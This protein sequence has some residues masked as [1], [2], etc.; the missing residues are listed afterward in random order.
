MKDT[1]SVNA[2]AHLRLARALPRFA[3]RLGVKDDFLSRLLDAADENPDAEVKVNAMIA[4]E[5][6]KTKK[7][8][9]LPLARPL[10][11]LAVQTPA[12]SKEPQ[13]GG[14]TLAEWITAL[15]SERT[16]I[17]AEIALPHCGPEGVRA[18]L[19]RDHDGVLPGLDLSQLSEVE[20][21]AIAPVLI[22]AMG[23]TDVLVRRSAPAWI[24]LLP[25]G[26]RKAAVPALINALN[27]ADVPVRRWAAQALGHIGADA[28]EAVPQLID[29][30]EH[31][32]RDLR[33]MALGAL[34]G[35]GPAAK[36]AVPTLIAHFRK[37]KD[38][39]ERFS[40]PFVLG[41]IGPVTPEVIPTM[42]AA[43]K[44]P[45]M[46][47]R[48]CAAQ[49][50]GEMHVAEAVPALL[51]VLKSPH[52]ESIVR[53]SVAQALGKLGAS[54]EAIEP[55][56]EMARNTKMDWQSRGA[57]MNALVLVDADGT[58]ALKTLEGNLSDSDALVL[59]NTADAIAMLGEKAKPAVAAISKML[60]ANRDKSEG[61]ETARL[62][63]VQALAK[64]GKCDE[65][66]KALESATNDPNEIVARVAK[67]ALLTL[68]K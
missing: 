14:H 57:A 51:E 64:I 44:D 47:T 17:D 43:L 26:T 55:L 10:A 25:A 50:L 48:N 41:K 11:A 16:K 52:E 2:A 35:I 60:I 29:A 61:F 33:G 15:K 34:G 38:E 58:I 66:I 62:E 65:A 27:D 12:V 39:Y 68:K 56:A 6:W 3:I 49:G 4:R 8:L 5:E 45:G 28:K 31:K 40:I 59:I 9:P 63:A 1:S 19:H 18:L 36:D 32:D 20:L 7:L 24:E 46:N 54:K 13:Y 21:N 22:E 37:E 42:L 23:D 53:N 67:E 30:L